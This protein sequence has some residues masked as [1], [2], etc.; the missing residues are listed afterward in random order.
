MLPRRPL[1]RGVEGDHSRAGHPDAHVEQDERG[2]RAERALVEHAPV[3]P[4]RDDLLGMHG[5]AQL[6]PER[7]PHQDVPDDLDRPCGRA[8]AAADERGEHEQHRQCAR[9]RSKVCREKSGGRLHGDDLEQPVQQRAAP[10]RVGA[11]GLQHDDHERA[12]RQRDEEVGAKLR[13]AQVACE[14]AIAEHQEMQREIGAAQEHE[15][16][17]DQRN[18]RAVEIGDAGVVRRYA[19]CRDSREAVADRI[20]RC[21]ARKPETERTGSRET[22][23]NEPERLR[24]LRD[25][26]REL[27]VLDRTRRLGLVQ[28]HAADA[29]HRHERDCQNH[30]SHAAEPVDLLAVVEDRLRQLV[31]ADDHGRAGR[32]E[33]G[34]PLEV[35]VERIRQLV[36]ALEQVRGRGEPGGEEPSDRNDEKSFADSDAPLRVG[37]DALQHEAGSTRHDSCDDEGVER[38]AVGERERD[39]EECGEAE[40]LP[41]RPDEVRR[42]REVDGE[43]TRTADPSDRLA[44]LGTRAP[45]RPTGRWRPR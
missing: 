10:V 29:E 19:R 8:G 22:D 17:E 39:R 2:C 4:D 23:V 5:L 20:E 32:R 42:R 1:E 40:V 28:R 15:H 11:R 34:H 25:A 33:A 27:F 7:L 44:H 9:P 37:G 18:R 21:H 31:E 30:D 6:A 12:E 3:E 24:G 45:R 36:A 38:L 43:A 16:H 14:A 41:Q 13:V 26:R 35:G